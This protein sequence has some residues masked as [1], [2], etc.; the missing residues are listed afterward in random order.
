MEKR[1]GTASLPPNGEERPIF[2]SIAAPVFNEESHIRNVVLHWLDLLN[3]WGVESEVVLTN[4]GSTDR[5]G[6][7]LEELRKKDFRVQVIHFP[8]NQGYGSALRSSIGACRGQ[9]IVTIDSDGQFE[10]GDI[11]KFLPL[12][13]EG[14]FNGINGRRFQKKDSYFKVFADR[15][16]NVIVRFLFGTRLRDTNCA[17]KIISRSLLQGLRLESTGFPL[18]TEIVLKLERK[19]AR[20]C[21]M[22]VNHFPRTEGLSKVGSLR[23]SWRMSMFLIYLR[24]RFFLHRRGIIQDL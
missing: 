15:V 24:F 1:E 13:Q 8:K 7:M 17:L 22:P 14:K 10:L 16:L 21:E 20:L 19:K 9:Y 4:D 3:R 12:L 6:E 11:E 18:P 2:I 5:T 23:T